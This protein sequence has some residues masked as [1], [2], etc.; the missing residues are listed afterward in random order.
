VAHAD[1]ILRSPRAAE[2][3]RPE[4]VVQLGAPAASKVLAQWLAGSG[5]EVVLVDPAGTGLDPDRLAAVF[6]PTGA[7][8]SCDALA[9]ALDRAGAPPPQTFGSWWRQ[10]DDA[11]AEAIATCA[12]APGG[13][14]SEVAL[15]R[16]TVAAAGPDDV[17]V[18]SSSMPVRDV[19][20]YSA[21]REGL[22]VLANRGANGIDGVVSTA[23]GAALGGARS[24]LL[25]GDLALLH[26]AGGLLGVAERGAELRVVVV[27]NGGGGIFSF[28]P[29]AAALPAGVFERFFGTPQA[30]QPAAL[31]R[32]HGVPTEEVAD[33]AQVVAA[34]GRLAEHRGPVAALVVRTGRAANVAQHEAV[35]RAVA[36]AVDARLGAG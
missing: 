8:A 17:L 6:V 34:L 30:L 5:A 27:D 10:L 13:Q 14:A 2:A 16:A 3:L 22:R 18:V 21:P 35:H 26:D 28:L 20:W 33:G 36:A 11:A 23:V 15:A 7:G 12:A 19:E 9:D 32:L 31:L 1:A 25:V 29:Q 4:V 24:W